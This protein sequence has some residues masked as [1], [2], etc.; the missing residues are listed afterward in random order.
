MYDTVNVCGFMSGV[1][2]VI[3]KLMIYSLVSMNAKMRSCMYVVNVGSM[4]K[5]I[6]KGN[7]TVM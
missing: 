7:R 3:Q 4:Q 5:L 2:A 6:E 1:K